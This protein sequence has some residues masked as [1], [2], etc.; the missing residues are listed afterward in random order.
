MSEPGDDG[1]RVPPEEIR[2]AVVLNGGVSLAVWMGGVVL[3]LDRLTRAA[4]CYQHLLDMVGCVARADVISGTSAGGINGAALAMSQVN[5][6]ADL[7]SLRDLWSEQGRMEELLRTP[8]RGAP[9]SLLRGDEFFLPRLEEMLERLTVGFDPYP[10]EERPIDLRIT[11]TLLHGYPRAEVDSLGQPL[12]QSVHQGSFWFRRDPY[13][14]AAPPGADG[15]RDDF[16]CEG[17]ELRE[18]VSRLA[19]AARSSA[20]FP[21]AFEPSFVPVHGEACKDGRPDMA[22]FA[23]WADQ[24][25]QPDRSRYVVDG[26]VLA[27]TPTRE[28]LEA[29]D[30]MPAKDAVRRVMLLVFPHASASGPE[31]A[32]D[33]QAAMPTTV[34][35]GRLLFGAMSSQG[36]R[37]YVERVNEHNRAAAARRGGR[38]ALLARLAEQPN[39]AP[40]PRSVAERLYTLVTEL[41]PHYRD[42]RI[43]QAARNLATRQLAAQAERSPE[44]S[45]DRVRR[46]SEAAQRRL[47]RAQGQLPYVPADP[48]P[49]CA[50][51]L[52]EDGTG[53]PWGIAMAE[54]LASVGLDLLK[55][56]AWV[57]PSIDASSTAPTADLRE[58]LHEARSTLRRLREEIDRP[59]AE[60]R[61]LDLDERYWTAR[62]SRY[63][64]LMLPRSNGTTDTAAE[65]AGLAP[66]ATGER[67]RAIVLE[68]GH[69]VAHARE[70]LLGL[71]DA[72]LARGDLDPWKGLLAAEPTEAELAAGLGDRPELVWLA[73]LVGLEI[74]TNCL[75][76]EST[77]LL[78]QAVEL[79][80][81]SLQTRSPF[82]EYSIGPRD[83]AGGLALGRFSGFLKRSWR[84]N[85]WIWG[86]LDG[87]TMLCRVLFDPQRLRRVALLKN[88]LTPLRQDAESLARQHIDALVAELFGAPPADPGIAATIE[89]AIGELTDVH[90]S[91][92]AD[93]DLPPT[94]TRLAE[95]AAWG[96]HVRIAAEELP[97]LRQAV[98]ADRLAGADTRSRGEL[99]LVEYENLLDELERLPV[100]FPRDEGGG[101]ALGLAALTAFDR[102]GVGREPLGEE[103]ASDQ[104]IRTAATAAAVAVT[105]ADSEQAGLRAARPITRTLR[106]GALLPYW[107]IMGLTKGGSTARFLGLFGL[108]VGGALLM[109]ALL[110]A[111]PTWLS[112]P[113]GA[114]GAGALLGAFGYAALRTGTVLHG[115]VLLSPVIPLLA[116]ALTDLS[117]S[118]AGR[119][120]GSVAF[121]GV[122]VVAA[123]QIVIGSLPAQVRTPLA[124]AVDLARRPGRLLSVLAAVALVVAAFSSGAVASTVDF[125]AGVVRWLAGHPVAVGV[126]GTVL[127]AASAGCATMG[128]LA[129]RRWARQDGTWRTVRAEHPAAITSGWAFVYGLGY[130]G[131]GALVLRFASTAAGGGLADW[132]TGA[133]WWVRATLVTAA[134]F[135]A[136]LLLVVPWL[137]PWRARLRINRRLVRLATSTRYTDA[138]FPDVNRALLAQLE[139]EGSLYR[140]LVTPAP[141]A[142]DPPSDLVL[143]RRGRAVA[144]HIADKLGRS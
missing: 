105:L 84:I 136:T 4:S 113:A 108:A 90:D 143:S 112:G 37:T 78:D 142:G 71:D 61:G 80:Q 48:P 133:H 60:R 1:D 131:V 23:S 45:F 6:N 76:D 22:R 53:W 44:W 97:M 99:F 33:Q 72:G 13:E 24:H 57:V 117:T 10:A 75:A 106:G 35:G 81:I 103:A 55:R 118:E 96:L 130:L 139:A 52:T 40:D 27:N 128:G 69:V 132:W 16:A 68:V 67:V 46:A 137:V 65:P 111:L 87:A 88:Q 104:L 9:V 21:F 59:W 92:I 7:R 82:V 11:T 30:R 83:K 66:D 56:L 28:A 26:G 38:A 20:S 93:G 79:V 100:D 127:L 18:H 51:R 5:A 125:C 141:S 123:G 115:L 17:A 62:L 3:E 122:G 58:R 101:V 41:Y 124:V 50:A 134:V 42:L 91:A 140:Y 98:L 114:L 14:W 63:K 121:V 8:F 89:G 15:A 107:A 43:R 12:R 54:R 129:L 102:A 19:L 25:D 70:L 144:A 2:F 116:Y 34:A 138:N 135:A 95:L 119:A 109:V 36:N 47:F 120:N 85:D 31:P 126:G 64:R 86:R 110:G 73:R 94:F 39:G 49:S 74:A 77:D 29:I 32:A